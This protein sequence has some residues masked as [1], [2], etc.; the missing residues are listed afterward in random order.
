MKIKSR[1]MITISQEIVPLFLLS[2]L[3]AINNV[4]LPK[5]AIE[6]DVLLK[7]LAGR[8]FSVVYS[9]CGE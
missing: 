4:S 7:S 2:L 5:A 9:F 1:P 6:P 8:C 3:L